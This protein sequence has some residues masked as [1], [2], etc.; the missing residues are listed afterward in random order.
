[1]ECFSASSGRVDGERRGLEKAGETRVFGDADDAAVL[2]ISRLFGSVAG[3]QETAE[4]RLAREEIRGGSGAEDAG[5]I[6]GGIR[7]GEAVAVKDVRAHGAEIV[8][9]KPARATPAG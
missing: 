7:G 1:M 3:I 4:C 6:A 8:E 5:G 2:L 9:R